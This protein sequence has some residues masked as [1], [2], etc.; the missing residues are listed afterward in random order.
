MLI[1]C[2]KRKKENKIFK[3]S[4]T[5]KRYMLFN[6]ISENNLNSLNCFLIIIL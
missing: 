4:G 5:I 3:S 1:N 2:K 6:Y